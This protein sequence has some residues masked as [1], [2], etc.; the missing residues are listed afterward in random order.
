MSPRRA[1][2]LGTAG[3]T[4]ALGTDILQR[5]GI[6]PDKG[7]LVVT[8]ATGG[9]GCLAVRL[10]SLLGY[11]VYAVSGKVERHEWLKSLGA[12]DVLSRQSVVGDSSKPLLE[13]RWAGAIDTV[14]GLVLSGLLRATT[15]GGCVA[16]CGLV[17]GADLAL[18]VYPF[19]L[20]GITLAGIDSA[21][22]PWDKRVA[23]W[24][25]LAGP[26]NIPDLDNLATEV[27]LEQLDERVAQILQGNMVGRTIVRLAG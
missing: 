2:I 4:A 17:G 26:W 21:W 12:R 18:T 5:H 7:P 25:R 16:A 10:L 19:I 3:F 9:V 11:A 27:T 23:I 1:M 6:T 14:G 15:S 8:G 22:T 20:R 24:Q 13:G